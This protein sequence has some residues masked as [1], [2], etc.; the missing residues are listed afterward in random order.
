MLSSM[1]LLND[2]EMKEKQVY[3]YNR[4]IQTLSKTSVGQRGNHKRDFLFDIGQKK[5]SVA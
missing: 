1:T 3:Q 5:K 2:E 4:C